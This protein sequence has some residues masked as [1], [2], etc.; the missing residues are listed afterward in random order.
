MN[1][2]HPV[3]PQRDRLAPRSAGTG[4]AHIAPGF[5]GGGTSIPAALLRIGV[6]LILA[7]LCLMPLCGNVWSAS[8]QEGAIHALPW[9]TGLPNPF[10][11]NNGQHVKTADDWR[12]R[13]RELI[14]LFLRDEY[15]TMPPMPQH[16]AVNVL[17]S[18]RSHDVGTAEKIHLAM[19][20]GHKI[21][22]NLDLHS[23]ATAGKHPAIIYLGRLHIHGWLK[24][25]ITIPTH[26]ILSR[27]YVLA[28]VNN[29]DIV[30]DMKHKSA[31]FKLYPGYTWGTLSAEAWEIHGIVSYLRTRADVNAHQIILVGFSRWGKEALL[32]G[33]LNKRIAM[34]GAVC[35]GCAGA[36]CFR[37]K[38]GDQETIRS[39]TRAFPAWYARRFALFANQ[40]QRLPFDQFEL[41]GLV[42]PRLLLLTQ[43]THDPWENP[44]GEQISFIAAKQ[45]FR[46]TGAPG[47]IAM[48]FH[49]GVHSITL[50]DWQAI[51]DFAD[52]HLLG[53]KP[54]QL[55]FDNLYYAHAPK[56]F[57]WKTP[58]PLS[59]KYQENP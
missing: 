31:I 18:R 15:G 48:Y 59:V 43:A 57:K 23:P 13:R 32:A 54:A 6:G 21:T 35:P 7:M 56:L 46:F 29:A 8:R 33:A 58:L 1:N 53:K 52:Q 4:H 41:M 45:I 22:L 11:L 17:S 37:F 38:P 25:Y 49:P 51:L 12:L 14:R 27:G 34:V 20:S 39:T 19:G 16:V 10:I 42:A 40:A 47:N 3:P 26:E 36:G 28:G 5:A 30:D 55:K 2:Q 44:E 24:K 9:Q 50:P